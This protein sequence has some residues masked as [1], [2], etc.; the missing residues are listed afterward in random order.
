MQ[1]EWAPRVTQPT[2]RGFLWSPSRAPAHTVAHVG[3][4]SLMLAATEAQQPGASRRLLHGLDC[5]GLQL[6]GRAAA[7]CVLHERPYLP[8]SSSTHCAKVAS[9]P[10]SESA[11]DTLRLACCTAATGNLTDGWPVWG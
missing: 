11:P 7:A 5:F 4:L 2:P 9:R 3:L 10:P 8:T 6:V 1:N